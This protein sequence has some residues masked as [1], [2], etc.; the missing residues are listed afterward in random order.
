MHWFRER[1]GAVDTYN[2]FAVLRTPAGL[3]EPHLISMAQALLDHHDILR[4]RLSVPGD[5]ADWSLETL[6]AGAVDAASAVRRTDAAGRPEQDWAAL[7]RQE[8]DAARDRLRPQEGNVLQAVWFD[9]GPDRRGLLA[10]VIHHLAIDS[11]S[12]RILASD[13]SAAWQAV[14]KGAAIALDPVP[15]SF[16]R[17]SQVLAEQAHTRT[18]V[19]ELPGWLE[20][21]RPGAARFGDRPRMPGHDREPG[22]V[23]H[24]VPAGRVHGSIADHGAVAVQRRHQR[25]SPHRSRTGDG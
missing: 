17:W 1:G 18:T 15:A 22:P 11:I 7:V 8:S 2:Q 13:L 16:R 3:T 20:R 4:L 12:W 25:R 21:L 5:E 19:A 9:A 23:L 6:P 24:R 14:E 10:L